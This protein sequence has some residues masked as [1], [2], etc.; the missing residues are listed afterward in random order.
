MNSA[1]AVATGLC[2]ERVA[3]TGFEPVLQPREGSDTGCFTYA[4]VATG[5]CH[6]ASESQSDALDR[7][8]DDPSLRFVRPVDGALS[9]IEL[10]TVGTTL[11]LPAAESTSL[12]P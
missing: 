7:S 9:R 8:L 2:A 12:A 1:Q 10:P 5:G 3:P 4:A 11:E 6:P